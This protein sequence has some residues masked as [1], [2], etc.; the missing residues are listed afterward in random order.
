MA[1][2]DKKSAVMQSDIDVPGGVASY[3]E[4]QVALAAKLPVYGMGKNLLHNWYFVGGGSQQGGGQF[5]INSRGLTKYSAS[6]GS[7]S[8]SID[9]WIALGIDTTIT[10]NGLLCNCEYADGAHYFLQNV[11]NHKRCIGKEL[12]ASAILSDSTGFA[13]IGIVAFGSAFPNGYVIAGGNQVAGSGLST[14]A[15]FTVL[16]GTEKLEIRVGVSDYDSGSGSVTIKAVKLEL[17]DTQTL[18]HQDEDGNWVLNEIPDYEE[19][20]IRCRT[21]KADSADAYANKDLA[22]QQQLATVEQTG[23]ASRAYAAGEYLCYNGLLYRVT[24]AIAAGGA[25]TPGTNCES[26]TVEHCLIKSLTTTVT[27]DDYGRIPGGIVPNY[28]SIVSNTTYYAPVFSG[29]NA[30]LVNVA[31]SPLSLATNTEV[32]LTYYYL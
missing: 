21:S 6:F 30:R 8:N 23:T 1:I 18:A 11:E 5:P 10:N 9:R 16:D 22:T 7:A 14:I 17:G 24:V 26:T 27:T 20:L 28:V 13:R 32:S 4:N 29:G 15:S 2:G 25:I 19:E 3:D 12:T 31:S